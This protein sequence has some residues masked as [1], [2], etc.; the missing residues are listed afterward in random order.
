MVPRWDGELKLPRQGFET[1]LG[2]PC[3]ECG[4]HVPVVMEELLGSGRF[5][6]SNCG[7]DLWVDQ[8]RSGESLS[9]LRDNR[10]LL[11][12]IAASVPNAEW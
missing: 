5:R 12:R 10:A 2:F 9:R 7:L 8:E 6:C 3:P 11:D 1:I 4:T